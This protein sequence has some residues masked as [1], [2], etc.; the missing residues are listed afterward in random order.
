M[1]RD[2]LKYFFF[3]IGFSL[4]VFYGYGGKFGV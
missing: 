2:F 1:Y 3:N 4:K